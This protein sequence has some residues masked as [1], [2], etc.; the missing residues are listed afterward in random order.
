MAYNFSSAYIGASVSVPTTYPFTMFVRGYSTSNTAQQVA[1]ALMVGSGDAYNG[2]LLIMDGA[3]SGDPARFSKFGGVL[4]NS[5]ASYAINTWYA[6]A[7]RAASATALDVSLDGVQTAG[8]STSV[9]FKT[10][11]QFQIGARANPSYNLGM[12][13]D[14]ACA[15]V[16][17]VQLDDDELVSLAKGF[18]PR[19]IRPQSL[20]YYA[21]LVRELVLPVWTP[22]GTPPTMSVGAGTAV[23]SAH[24][25][26]YGM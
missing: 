21:P 18:S 1:M 14:C 3:F 10:L 2:S 13:G 6:I 23:P 5:A 25:R 4:A 22:A 12:A 9:S 8:A 26:S 20:K 11:T 24:P 17:D 19:R 15:A 7:G 16:W